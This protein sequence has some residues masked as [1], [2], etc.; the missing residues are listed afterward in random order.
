MLTDRSTS[1]ESRTPV[2]GIAGR[3]RLPVA[4]I[5]VLLITGAVTGLQFA[6]P[7]ILSSLRRRPGAISDGQW[8]RMIT[9]MLV[10]SGGWPHFA[11]NAVAIAVVGTIAERIFGWRRWLILYFVSG[12]IGEVAGYA[13]KPDGAG[14]SVGG[15]G[16]LGG[17]TTWLLVR[18]GLPR[19]ARAGA[20]V[21]LIGT[22]TLTLY[23]DVHGPPILAGVILAAIM[24]RNQPG[25]GSL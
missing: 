3:S 22:L 25:S 17:V 16:L 20:I 19:R 7:E 12:I 24:L 1:P 8:W 11:F 21:V 10:H 4:T 2:T 14:A 13:W 18:K 5:S 15:A 9:P 23:H 6:Y